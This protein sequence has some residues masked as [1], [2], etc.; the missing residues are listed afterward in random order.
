M[1]LKA[2]S[3]YWNIADKSVEYTFLRRRDHFCS[4]EIKLPP[5][6]GR[7]PLGAGG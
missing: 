2:L 7:L 3:L 4:A 1:S 5:T 6:M